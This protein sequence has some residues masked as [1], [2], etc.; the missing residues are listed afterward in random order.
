MDMYRDPKNGDRFSDLLPGSLR[1]SLT[2]RQVA[3]LL[4]CDE[5][6]IFG[7]AKFLRRVANAG[8]LKSLTSPEIARTIATYPG[9]DMKA[10]SKHS[11]A[12]PEDNIAALASEYTSAQWDGQFVILWSALM[13]IAYRHIKFGGI[14]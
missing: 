10:Y 12:W 13:R 9:I 6:N 3:N 1:A 8:A 7:V 5:F 4:T 11:T 14:L 2:N